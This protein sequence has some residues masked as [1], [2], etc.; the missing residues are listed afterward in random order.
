M[1]IDTTKVTDSRVDELDA[2]NLQFGKLYADH[3]LT[4]EF[5]G[6]EWQAPSILPYGDICMSPA[7]TFIHYGQSL[8]EGIKAYKQVNGDIAIFRP[9]DNWERFNLSARRMAMAEVPEKLFMEGMRQ[10]IELDKDWVPNVDGSS[11]YIRP[12]MYATDAFI[13]VKPADNFR[14]MI[15]TSPAGAYY[16]RPTRIYVQNKYVRAFP[17]GIGFTKAAGNYGACMLPTLETRALGYD[18]IL[19]TDGFTHKNVQEIGTMNVFF[20]LGDKVVTPDLAEGTILAGVTRDSVIKLL[21]EKGIAVEERPLSIDEILH[22]YQEGRLKEA[23]G[24]GTAAVIAPISELFYDGHT[25]MLPPV[26]EWEIAN[27]LKKELAD[28]RYGRIPDRHNWMFKV[29]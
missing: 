13:G 7:T 24:A 20:V 21:L 5:V 22:H 16:N 9:K 18:Q 3:M 12:F 28:I 27:S 25:M 6:G 29:C 15:I 4:A 14:F 1:N 2:E 10:L 17:G 19:W 26:E 23:F 8:F 11:L